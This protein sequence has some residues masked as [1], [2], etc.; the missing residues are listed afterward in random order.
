M[1]RSFLKNRPATEQDYFVIFTRKKFQLI[2]QRARLKKTLQ[3]VEDLIPVI[4][5]PSELDILPTYIEYLISLNGESRR[6]RF[7]EAELARLQEFRQ[8]LLDAITAHEAGKREPFSSQDYQ[9]VG[10]LLRKLRYFLSDKI[11]QPI[12]ESSLLILERD[13]PTSEPLVWPKEVGIVLDHLRSPY[14]VGAIIRTMECVGVKRLISVGY[15]PRL[16]SRQ[17]Q[18][19]AMGCET[20][21]EVEY[22]E[23]SVA[24]VEAL[25]QQR[26]QIYVLETVFPSRSVFALQPA[27]QHEEN[28]ALVMGNEEFGVDENIIAMADHL[29]H[30]PT[31]GKKN[32]LNVSIAFSIAIYQF[33][34]ALFGDGPA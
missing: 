6:F 15:T 3:I 31:F 20:E 5:R 17:V 12:K 22:V 1:S 4:Q 13:A 32:S 34:A 27:L 24:A 29:L 2:G 7:N 9:Q 19:A 26:F 8:Q 18:R 28:I 23:D 25:Q 14:N 11:Q 16:D 21:V 30:I 33:W 10:K